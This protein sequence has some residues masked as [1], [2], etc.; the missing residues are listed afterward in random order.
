MQNAAFMKNRRK[1]KRKREG[2]HFS[3]MHFKLRMCVW[4]PIS[5][6]YCKE[7]YFFIYFFN[8]CIM[9][10]KMSFTTAHL[11]CF[12]FSL[13]FFFRFSSYHLLAVIDWIIGNYIILRAPGYGFCSKQVWSRKKRIFRFGGNSE[14]YVSSFVGRW[15]CTIYYMSGGYFNILHS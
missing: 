11:L 2:R 15:I 3:Q 6:G 13:C 5:V 12:S 8:P 9:F 4:Y 7:T 14:L 1:R 10:K